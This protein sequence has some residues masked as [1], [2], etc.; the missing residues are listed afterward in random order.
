MAKRKSV[1]R[2]EGSNSS[3]SRGPFIT[4]LNFNGAENHNYILIEE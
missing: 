2:E 1:R 3:R 4:F